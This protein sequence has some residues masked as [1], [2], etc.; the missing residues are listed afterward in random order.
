VWRD[1]GREVYLAAWYVLLAS[2]AAPAANAD[3]TAGASAGG[4]GGVEVWIYSPEVGYLNIRSAPSTSGSLITQAQHNDSVM[5]L[6]AEADVKAKVGQRGQ[7]LNVRLNSGQVGYGAANYFSPMSPPEPDASL[8]PPEDEKISAA[9]LG[10]VER[11]V[12]QTWNR[13]GGSLQT[14]AGQLGIDPGVAVAVWTVESAGRPFGPDGRM[15]IRFENHIFYNRWGKNAQNIFNQHF[16]F[17]SDRSWTGHQ[18][19]PSPNEPWRTFHGNQNTEWE[20]L[21]FACKLDDTA[22]KFSISMGGPQIMGFNYAALGYPSVQEMFDA[23]GASEGNQV[24]GF[25]NFVRSR[26][27]QTIQALQNSNFKAFA[28]VYNGPGQAETYGNLIQNAYEAYQR[29]RSVSFAVSF[30]VGDMEP[31]E[32]FEV[33]DFTRIYGIGPKTTALLN[34]EG[35]YSFVDLAYMDVDYLMDILG[36]AARRL[37][38]IDTWPAQAQLAS[39]GDWEG[40]EKFQAKLKAK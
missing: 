16:T 32:M 36:S 40:L 18:W 21:E 9:G 8:E 20:T 17:N 5:A 26:G 14:L 33:D 4:D 11:Q 23:F 24:I 28:R 37:R 3:A 15:T 7:W 31:P 1:D 13:L 34:N 12:A 35:L 27:S 10:G 38:W 6:G 22:G 2:S 29:L 39:W 19:R 25:F 30:G